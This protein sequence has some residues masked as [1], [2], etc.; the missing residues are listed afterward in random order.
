[1]RDSS[2]Q[3]HHQNIKLNFNIELS[4]TPNSIHFMLEVRRNDTYVEKEITSKLNHEN[5]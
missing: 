5:K 1:M 2:Y 3:I 4:S